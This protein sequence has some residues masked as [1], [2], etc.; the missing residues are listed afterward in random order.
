[1]NHE[2]SGMNRYVEQTPCQYAHNVRLLRSHRRSRPGF[3]AAKPLLGRG[4]E[5][6]VDALAGGELVAERAQSALRPRQQSAHC[7]LVHEDAQSVVVAQREAGAVLRGGGR[8]RGRL[9]LHKQVRKRSNISL[10]SARQEHE[11][12]SCCCRVF[13]SKTYVVWQ[14]VVLQVGRDV[15]VD[16]GRRWRL[17]H[18]GARNLGLGTRERVVD[19]NATLW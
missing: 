17:P 3:V 6:A 7:E 9:H 1:M 13:R 10:R 12:H 18:A 5:G 14:R 16:E 15:V 2:I 19:H 4:Q 11:G 8:S